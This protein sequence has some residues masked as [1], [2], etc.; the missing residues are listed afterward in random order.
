MSKE[1]LLAALY[2][3]Q[4]GLDAGQFHDELEMLITLVVGVKRFRTFR[5]AA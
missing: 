5:A 1:Q 3:I 2:S 4:N